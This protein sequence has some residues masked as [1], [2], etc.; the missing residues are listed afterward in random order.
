MMTLLAT[1]VVFGLLGLVVLA[2]VVL[3]YRG[4]T[5]HPRAQRMTDVVV[6][7]AR[8]VH[9]GEAPP[10]GV[11]TTPEKARQV[12]ERIEAVE[13]KVRRGARVLAQRGD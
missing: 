2:V 5:L 3:L 13:G 1:Y 12:S 4:R 9:P 6:T 11:L 10:Q 7:T 8:R